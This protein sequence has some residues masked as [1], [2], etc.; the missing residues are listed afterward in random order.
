MVLQTLINSLES[1]NVSMSM[2]EAVRSVSQREYC[3]Q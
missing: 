3:S 2:N 1:M